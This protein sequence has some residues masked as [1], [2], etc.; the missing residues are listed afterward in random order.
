MAYIVQI[1][2]AKCG[3]LP[4]VWGYKDR[5]GAFGSEEL[6]FEQANIG[7]DQ[8]SYKHPRQQYRIMELETMQVIVGKPKEVVTR[9]VIVRESDL[10]F[11]DIVPLEKAGYTDA[12]A[13]EDEDVY[14]DDQ[15]DDRLDCGCHCSECCNCGDCGNMDDYEDEGE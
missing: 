14:I 9:P 6:T 15:D 4:T 8:A 5:D 11:L 3:W 2:D 1:Y 13:D 7:L 10:D 12:M